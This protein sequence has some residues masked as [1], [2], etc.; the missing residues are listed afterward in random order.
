MRQLS[1]VIFSLPSVFFTISA[2]TVKKGVS[3]P[4]LPQCS[5]CY[6]SP[7]FLEC[8]CENA[9]AKR[10]LTNIDPSICTGPI[11]YDKNEGRLECT[12]RYITN[13]SF[14]EGTLVG[15][16]LSAGQHTWGAAKDCAL[17]LLF[18]YVVFKWADRLEPS[19][20]MSTT[21]GIIYH[22]YKNEDNLS[23]FDAFK[24]ALVA[25]GYSTTTVI[26]G[27]FALKKLSQTWPRIENSPFDEIL[28]LLT[29]VFG[30]YLYSL[31]HELRENK[32][33]GASTVI[34]K[35]AIMREE[36]VGND[37]IVTLTWHGLPNCR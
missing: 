31:M 11:S 35:C 1:F 36:S 22:F 20:R 25:T 24:Q 6:S 28:A 17:A 29:S 21:V 7:H 16:L 33:T 4:D 9:R 37:K 2:P 10:I 14:N 18:D 23:R 15:Q 34:D 30:V 13:R 27:Y 5:R 8:E 26:A 3:I 32:I 19:R 12:N